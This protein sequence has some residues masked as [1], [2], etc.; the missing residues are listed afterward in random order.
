[1][2]ILFLGGKRFFGNSLLKSLS[3]S[4]KYTIYVVYR[5]KKPK[6]E[7]KNKIIFIKCERNSAKEIYQKLYNIKFDIIYDNNCYTLEN[8]KKILFN[9]KYQDYIYIFSSTVMSYTNNYIYKANKKKVNFDSKKMKLISESA[10]NYSNNKAAIEKFLINSKKKYIIFRIHNL[11]GVNDHTQITNFL[12]NLSDTDLDYFKLLP[13]NKIQFA[14]VPDV[15]KI[16]QNKIMKINLKK[17]SSEIFNIAN[18]PYLLKKLIEE[19]SKYSIKFKNLSNKFEK[20]PINLN[21]LVTRS[22]NERKSHSSLQRIYS[23]LSKKLNV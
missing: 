3:K 23:Q 8:C 17:F 14:F 12:F 13:N 18:K 22:L 5:K 2:Q 10:K 11:L 19:R 9:L 20:F 7:K 4:E 21:F 16:I 6:I 1:M 15:T